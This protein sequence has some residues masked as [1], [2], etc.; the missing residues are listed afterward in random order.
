EDRPEKSLMRILEGDRADIMLFG[1]THVPYHRILSYGKDGQTA[2]RHAINIGSVG[3]PK[4]GDPRACYV[5][6][7]ID[8]NL[9]NFQK[10]S[11]NVEIRRID[12]D[13]EKAALAVEKSP[14]P[15]KYAE[16][17]RMAR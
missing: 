3:K 1:H 14:L 13:I 2:Y 12:Y 16:S 10:E 6:M 11:V 7:T 8:E 15:D 4:D 9:S 5:T 17:L